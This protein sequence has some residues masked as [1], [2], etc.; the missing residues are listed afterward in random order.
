M[1]SLRVGVARWVLTVVLLILL[2]LLTSRTV[3]NFVQYFFQVIQVA[4]W[5]RPSLNT[6]RGRSR[7]S[8]MSGGWA[9]G[10][11]ERSCSTERNLMADYWLLNNSRY[12]EN[13][14]CWGMMRNRGGPGKAPRLQ[15]V[16]RRM[17]ASHQCNHHF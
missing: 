3:G 7:T 17:C 9:Q 16:A 15:R 2:D 5:S 14:V 13:V 12:P 4:S 11:N 6:I 1:F 8:T 10:L